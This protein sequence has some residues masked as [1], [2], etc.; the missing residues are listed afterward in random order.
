MESRIF[1]IFGVFKNL[2]LKFF[3]SNKILSVR[4][5]ALNS[6]IMKNFKENSFLLRILKTIRYLSIEIITLNP[7]LLR[8][9]EDK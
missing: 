3:E 7:I 1:G 8:I 4:K 5:I 9:F 6:V 2:A